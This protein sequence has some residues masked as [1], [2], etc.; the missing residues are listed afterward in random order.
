[1]REVFKAGREINLSG[2]QLLHCKLMIRQFQPFLHQ[3]FTRGA[4]KDIFKIRFEGCKASSCKKGELF[5]VAYSLI[6]TVL[7][8]DPFTLTTSK[9]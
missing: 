6:I 3:P 2:F 1:M 4:F 9:M 7:I 5:N 8:E